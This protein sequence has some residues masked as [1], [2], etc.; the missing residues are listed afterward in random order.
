LVRKPSETVTE[1]SSAVLPG[2]LAEL[3][4]LDADEEQPASS[5]AAPTIAAAM[6]RRIPLP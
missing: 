6:T 5:T 4:V 2:E 3:A 1:G